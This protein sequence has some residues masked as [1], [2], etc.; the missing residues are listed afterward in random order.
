MGLLSKISVNSQV[1][2]TFY[3][4]ALMLF[5][6]LIIFLP[7]LFI[8]AP[9]FILR[10]VVRLKEQY[11]IHWDDRRYMFYVSPIVLHALGLIL[12]LFYRR[13]KLQEHF[14]VTDTQLRNKRDNIGLEAPTA[15]HGALVIEV[16]LL[17]IALG[18]ATFGFSLTY[19]TVVVII[20]ILIGTIANPILVYKDLK[21]LSEKEVSWSTRPKLLLLILSTSVIFLF[22]YTIA[23]SEHVFQ[24]LLEA[25][26]KDQRQG[27]RENA[28]SNALSRN[29][30]Y[31]VDEEAVFTEGGS[32]PPERPE[33]DS[34]FKRRREESDSN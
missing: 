2:L 21:R 24:F 22:V 27:G 13:N 32:E 15:I 14:Q 17:S 25:V 34:I 18:L 5:G 12:Y 6:A 20:L 33:D 8:L 16:I 9:F 1:N 31:D 23:R 30:G 3:P 10:D 4:K 26:R 29:E 19:V 7:F 11:D 28:T